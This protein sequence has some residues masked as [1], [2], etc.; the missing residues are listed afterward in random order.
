M[1]AKSTKAPAVA[2]TVTGSLGLDKV[3][4]DNPPSRFAGDRNR[5]R[6]D[7]M[8]PDSPTDVAGESELRCSDEITT[9]PER[10]HDL[11]NNASSAFMAD[12]CS[13]IFLPIHYISIVRVA[14][15]EGQG[16]KSGFLPIKTLQTKKAPR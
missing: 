8:P 11:R 7:R 13:Q 5:T 14:M 10:F 1:P 4:V 6:P 16:A 15:T 9:L 3:R 12:R 2:L